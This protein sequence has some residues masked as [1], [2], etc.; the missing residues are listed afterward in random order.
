[1]KKVLVLVLMAVVAGAVFAGGAKQTAAEGPA[2][3][4]ITLA[5]AASLEKAFTEE[6]IPL[7]QREHPAVQVEGVYDSSGRLQTQIENGLA[8]DVFFSAATAQMNNL[9][10]GGFV[11]AQA[12]SPLLENRIV[13]IKPQG[14]TT[15]VTAFDNV[16][17]AALIAVGDPQ[18]VPAGQYAR[19][20][21]T[22]IGNWDAIQAKL[23]LG[24]NVTEVL[25]WVA[26]AS[27]EVG[28]VYATDAASQPRVEVITAL[29]AGILKTPVIYPAAPLKAS[30][31]AQEAA[32][33]IAFLKSPAAAAVFE[34]YGFA[35][36]R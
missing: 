21:L 3:V 9:V 36:A 22:A 7:W 19:E 6:L 18:S 15:A 5:A 14:G 10:N 32:D 27:A 4:T 1:M 31:H 20:A 13:L 25:N 24:T 28:I 29:P 2:A 11:E 16:Q 30:A 17:R 23:S 26:A 34:K 12:V 35:L 8:A 33:F